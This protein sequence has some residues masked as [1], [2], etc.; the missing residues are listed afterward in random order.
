MSI[1]PLR[2]CPP[3]VRQQRRYTARR[4]REI[5]AASQGNPRLSDWDRQF[6]ADLDAKITKYYGYLEVSEKQAVIL[7]RI[8]D[9]NRPAIPAREPGL[10]ASAIT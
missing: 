9:A 7:L 4:V 3:E 10:T 6:L 5:V 8:E 2:E 1:L